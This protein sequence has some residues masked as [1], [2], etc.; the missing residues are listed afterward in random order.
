MCK[1]SM[2]REWK[3]LAENEALDVQIL[4]EDN[5]CECKDSWDNGKARYKQNEEGSCKDG[6]TQL[7]VYTRS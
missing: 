5:Q 1:R 6:G 2:Y 7:H 4:V 3:K